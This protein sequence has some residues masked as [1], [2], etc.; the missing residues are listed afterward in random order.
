MRFVYIAGPF[1][2]DPLRNVAKAID[3]ADK[4]RNAGDVPF[5]PH[6]NW[7]WGMRHPHDYDYWMDY[8][9]EWMLRCDIIV[10]IPGRSPG[11][12]IEVAEA[13]E[14]HIPVFTVHEYLEMVRVC[15]GRKK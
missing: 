3:I 15:K 12:D 6:L 11:A 9:R 13:H 14:R 4:V 10:R 7:F 8:D 5:I 2:S 1:T